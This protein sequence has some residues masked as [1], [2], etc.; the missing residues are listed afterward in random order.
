[1]VVAARLVFVNGAFDAAQS[2]LDGL[3]D[4]VDCTPLSQA[5]SQP[6]ADALLRRLFATPPAEQPADAFRRLNAAL[7]QDGVVLRVAAG[8]TVPAPVE[9]VF[10]GA[11]APDAVHWALRNLVELGE[12]ASLTLVERWLD[13]ADVPHLGNTTSLVT[14]AQ[15]ARLCHLRLQQGGAASSSIAS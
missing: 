1:G 4:G 3:P 13:Q 15:G 11:P 9:L 12:G 7:A 5:L 10:I 14:L 2:M 8:T 6:D